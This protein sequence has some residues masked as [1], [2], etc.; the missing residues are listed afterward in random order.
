MATRGASAPPKV[1]A[2]TARFAR[3]RERLLLFAPVPSQARRNDAAELPV[4]RT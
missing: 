4:K 2:L 3:Q 1:F